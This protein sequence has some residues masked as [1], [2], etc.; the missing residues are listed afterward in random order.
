MEHFDDKFVD[1]RT[2]ERVT[3]INVPPNYSDQVS[4]F[5][6]E[7]AQHANAFMQLSRQRIQLERQAL[8]AFDLAT[9]AEKKVGEEVIRLRE[10]MKLDSSWLYNMASQK[11]E[12]REPPNENG[13]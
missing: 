5:A 4:K 6:Q 3:T 9:E 7:N 10:R 13:E 1:Q 12:K 8:K 2:G 11:M